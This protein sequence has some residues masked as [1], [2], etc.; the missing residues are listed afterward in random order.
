MEAPDF[1]TDLANLK[2]KVEAGADCVITQLFYD[3]EYYYRFVEAA[4]HIGISVPIIPGLL[5]IVSAKQ[6]VR[7]TSMCGSCLPEELRM[8]LEA[9][10]DNNAKAE[11]IG[12]EQCVAQATDLIKNGVAGIH[13]YVLNRSSQMVRIMNRIQH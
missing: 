11:E 13:F 4:R 1:A 6:I 10:G 3:N 9:V 8:E 7:I 12:I 5:P 2:Q